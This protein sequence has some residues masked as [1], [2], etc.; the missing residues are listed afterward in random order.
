MWEKL[1]EDYC[2]DDSPVESLSQPLLSLVLREILVLADLI[3]VEMLV[4]TNFAVC[5]RVNGTLEIKAPD[6]VYVAR[7]NEPGLDRRSYTPELE[8]DRPLLVMEFL[9]YTD[10]DEY[11]NKPTHPVGKWFFY[12]QVLK[13]PVYVI[14]NPDGGLVECY[15]LQ[16]G[17]YRLAQP[18]E[19]GWN[20]IPELQLFLGT[21]QNT[22]DGRTG[23]WLRW[24]TADGE[25]LPWASET[26]AAQDQTIATQ[27]QAI[28]AQEQALEEARAREDRLLALLRSQ[29]ID[30][31]QS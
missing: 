9:S 23:Y 14:F 25:L 27:E 15:R 22:R 21:Q 29:G 16:D 20:W 11:S 12:E 3:T 2:L 28:A 6:W 8:G 30:P 19:N 4:A 24:W 1:P 17:Q 26:I 31:A 18:N 7:V 10:G 5:A 13:V